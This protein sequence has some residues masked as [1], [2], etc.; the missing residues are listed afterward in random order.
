LKYVGAD[1]AEHRPMVIHWAAPSSGNH[2]AN[3]SASIQPFSARLDVQPVV[4][5]VAPLFVF[6]E[7]LTYK[8][9]GYPAR[10]AAAR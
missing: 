1:N 3:R 5:V 7:L 2:E 8:V 4:R 6:K 9:E 10:S